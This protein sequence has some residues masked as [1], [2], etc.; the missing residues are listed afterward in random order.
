MLQELATS[1]P[2]VRDTFDEASE[3]LA[4]DLWR[5]VAVGPKEELDRT[6]HTQPVMLAAGVG[7]WRTW[8]AAGG[9]VPTLLAGHSLGEY[10]ALVA[11]EAIAFPDAV[12][13]VAERARLMQEAVP[14]EQGAMAAIIGLADADVLSLC[15]QASQGDVL[16]A[17]N[18]NAPGQVVVAGMRSA[19]LRAA[20]AAKD[21]GARAV[22]MLPV[23]VPAHSS[24]MRSA[25]DQLARRLGETAISPPRFPVLHNATAAAA[26]E[27]AE[28]RALLVRQ[29]YSPV[30]W[31]ETVQ[32]LGQEGA[33]IVIECGPGRVLA[34]LGRRIDKR[35]K[36]LPVFDTETLAAALEAIDAT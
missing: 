10:S 35:L 1:Y 16:E 21:G 33:T 2:A 6:E 34:G 17:V 22:M 19:V 18:F 4:Y 26:A 5:L 29:L 9:A 24:L 3:V 30:R 7:V 11:A 14:N 12:A 25:A 36:T 28:I 32:R 20:T 8:A 13:I 15:E 27:P 23:S 31:V